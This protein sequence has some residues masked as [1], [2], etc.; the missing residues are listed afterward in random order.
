MPSTQRDIRDFNMSSELSVIKN[1]SQ[2]TAYVAEVHA[3]MERDPGA[4][5]ADGK[6]LELLALLIEK[7]EKEGHH[8][9][10]PNPLEMI[11]FRLNELGLKQSDLV[12]MIGSKGRVSEVMAGKR[13]LTIP[14]IRRLSRG[15]G[16][17]IQLLVEEPQE[18]DASSVFQPLT[19]E[20]VRRGWIEKDDIAANS[21]EEYLTKLWKKLGVRQAEAA[22]FKKSLN[23]GLTGPVDEA[24]IRIWVARVVA[25][26]QASSARENFK[27]SLLTDDLLKELP[28]LSW[29][30]DGPLLAREYLAKLG[31]AL[32]VEAHLPG[33]GIDGASALDSDGFPV[34]GL[35]LRHDRLDNF[36]FTLLHECVHV[37]KHLR[38]P[39]DMFVDDTEGAGELDVKEAEANRLARD[40]LIP[41]AAW[42]N[43]SAPKLKTP[44]AVRE[45][46][47]QLRVSPAIVA[48]RIRRETGNYRIL[49]SLVG[50]KGVSK[51]LGEG[52]K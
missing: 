47:A 30:E 2:Y 36:W 22:Y 18:G 39:G 19:K 13:G 21:S 45:F 24:A 23:V 37:I 11:A 28:R 5:T 8:F 29:F 26:A 6:R 50:Y 17:P 14:M 43:S 27:R 42:R 49:S 7:Y 44:E 20:L 51:F 40:S 48:G 1:E 9:T 33:T 4:D 16:I 12:P 31:I 38:E 46:A 3:L 34:I 15:L 35:S 32:V 25:R 41:P 52:D 10:R